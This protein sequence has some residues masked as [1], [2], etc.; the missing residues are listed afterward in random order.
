MEKP[1]DVAGAKIGC[2]DGADGTGAD[3]VHEHRQLAEHLLLCRCQLLVGPVHDGQQGMV[4]AVGPPAS[5]PR[6][7]PVVQA[8]GQL[9]DGD[10]QKS[11]G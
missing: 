10:A 7:E 5:D 11:A 1:G 9:G 6:A 3:P 4:A 8:P 2:G